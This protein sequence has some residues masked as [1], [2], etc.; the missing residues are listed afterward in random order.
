[1]KTYFTRIDFD[2]DGAV[3][4]ADFEGMAK[5]FIETAKFSGDKAA[6]LTKTVLAIW[7]SISAAS[8]SDKITLDAFI[9]SAKNAISKP[10]TFKGPLPH[11][12][13][14][15]DLDSDGQISQ[16]EYQEFF[17][18]LGL[19]PALA[20]ASFKA[21]DTNNDGQLSM[22]EFSQ[23]G[24]EFFVKDDEACPTKLFWGPLV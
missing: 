20:E 15:V 18:I 17:R 11:F 8:G 19:D 23:A 12:F 2:G 16:A 1:M 21:I 6:E 7:D 10:E 3:T 24:V 9:A 22:D 5:R 13:H 4:K 14:A